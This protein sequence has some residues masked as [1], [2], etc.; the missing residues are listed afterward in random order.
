M[1]QVS[2]IKEG[3]GMT[4]LGLTGG[5]ATG[6]STADRIFEKYG[7]P[8]V[9]GD[10]VARE[11]VEIGKPALKKIVDTFG[12]ELLLPNGGL[13]RQKLGQL[14][15][16]DET[17]RQQLNALLDPYLRQEI[18]SQIKK[19]QADS[20]LVVADIPLL[21]EAGYQQYM[22]Q[23]AVVYLPKKEQ[24]KRLMARENLTEQAAAEKIASQ[25][26]IDEKCQQ[27]DVV[28]DNQG[29]ILA[30]E[31]QIVT[32]LKKEQFIDGTF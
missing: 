25:L 12:L 8:V 32:W 9:D 13:N 21:F 3:D 1:S 5:I 28:F 26:P 20:P 6:K 23:I 27:A 14:I 7:F 18:L 30:L 19:A 11:I 22:N 16:H 4:V 29:S 2:K 15:F 17:K 31:Q 10:L 24:I